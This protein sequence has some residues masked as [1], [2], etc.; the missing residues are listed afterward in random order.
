MSSG[1][2][3]VLGMEQMSNYAATMP[4]KEECVSDMEQRSS[5]AALLDALIKP[6]EKECA[7]GTV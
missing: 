5:D 1:E 2:E 3:W 7:L 4:K 6:D